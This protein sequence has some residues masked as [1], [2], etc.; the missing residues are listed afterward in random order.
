MAKQLQVAIPIFNEMTVLD[1]VGPYEIL[2]AIPTVDVVFVS[3][4]PGPY[5]DLPGNLSINATHSFEDVPNPDIIVVPGGLG[6]RKLVHD[7]ILISWLQ[8]V[9]AALALHSD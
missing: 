2:Q 7:K 1:A 5:S 3:Y 4:K 9:S 6:T 8:K